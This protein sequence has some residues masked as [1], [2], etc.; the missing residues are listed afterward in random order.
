VSANDLMVDVQMVDAKDS[1]SSSEDSDKEA[2]P[3]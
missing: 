3:L 1:C 2:D